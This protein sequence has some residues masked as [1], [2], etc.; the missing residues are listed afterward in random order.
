MVVFP[1]PSMGA[2][3]QGLHFLPVP[4]QSSV[5]TFSPCNLGGESLMGV[6]HSKVPIP[7][8]GEDAPL[9]R[10]M[11]RRQPCSPA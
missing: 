9:G 11:Q 4:Y 5:L 8:A 3:L 10:G 1:K 6:F 2:Y 7:G